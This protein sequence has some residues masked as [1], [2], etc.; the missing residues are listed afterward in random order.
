VQ[1]LNTDAMEAYNALDIDKAGGMLEEALRIANE[2]ALTG[3]VLAQTHL[4]L[5]IVFVAGVKDKDAGLAEF[6][7]ALCADPAAQIDPLSKSPDIDS[8]FQVATQQVQA[9]ACKSVAA[10]PPVVVMPPP[11]GQPPIGQPMPGVAP[12]PMQIPPPPADQVFAHQAPA[13]QLAQ[14]PLPLYLEVDP[15]AHAHEIFLYYQGLGMT[16]WKRVPMYRYQTGFAYQISCNDVWEPKVSYYVEALD[17]DGKVVGVGA[18]AAEPIVVSIV[19]TRAQAEPALPGAKSPSSCIA[20]ECP[21]GLAG[22]KQVGK[23]AIGESCG[24]NKDCQ[25][26]LECRSDSC[27]LIGGGGTEVP[28]Y[29]PVTGEVEVPYVDDPAK[30]KPSFV[31]LGFTVGIAYV[32]PGMVADRSPPDDEVFVDEMG[33]WI[34][35]PLDPGIDTRRLTLPSAGDPLHA[36]VLEHYAFIPDGDSAD[37]LGAYSGT[38]SADGTASGPDEY[39]ADGLLL[40]SRYCVRLKSAGMVPTFALRAAVGHFFTPKISAALL[41]RLQFS[42][43]EGTLANMLIG[44]RGEYMLTERKSRG[45]MISAFAGG[46]FGQIQARPGATGET[47]DSPFA[48]SGLFGGH[49]GANFRYRIIENFGFF[50]SPELDVQLPSFLLN[51]DLTLVGVEG[52]F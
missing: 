32:M 51:L 25:S 38:C 13:E 19:G 34:P 50:A 6:V 33:N 18:S 5:G 24:G 1:K 22:C 48:I 36:K 23:A 16:K 49:V 9:G 37:G 17:E 42:A 41:L 40:P 31:Q 12:I 14:T 11:I 4:N 10:P 26:G 15:L 21:P 47:K 39:A 2:A 8:V 46:T 30:F 7:S 20:K 28:E 52:A 45:L 44:A 43:G 3:P 27:A 35:N 29:N